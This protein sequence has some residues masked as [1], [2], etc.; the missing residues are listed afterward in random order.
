ME[1]IDRLGWAAGISFLAYGRR[2]G[3]RVN[4][5]EI[6]GRVATLLPPGWRPATSPV[7]D[8]LY[9]LVVGGAGPKSNIRRFNLL[10]EGSAR[11]ARTMDL[12]EVFN[13]LESNL[14]LYVALAARPSVFVHAG[15][16]GWR[17]RA[18]VI[19]GHSLSGKSTLVAAL[20]NA[21]ATY[22]SD[23]YAVL[24]ARGRVHPYPKPLSIRENNGTPPQKYP[25]EALLS[26]VG[27]RPL[28]VGLIVVTRYRA[29]ARWRPRS[30]SPGQAALALLGHTV[31]ARLDPKRALATLSEAVPRARALRG[32]RGEAGEMAGSLLNTYDGR[33]PPVLR[34]DNGRRRG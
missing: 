29:G 8:H 20:V 16:V 31:P 28:P 26:D 10:Y 7:V 22:Y 19:P 6:L 9:S 3:V 15:V 30:L 17:G 14:Q 27:A 11:V 25:A 1:K 32:V 18:I 24:D 21:G 13:L 2:I 5:P 33:R 34:G 4:N 12:D 23:E